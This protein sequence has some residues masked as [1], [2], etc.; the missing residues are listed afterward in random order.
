MASLGKL[1]RRVFRERLAAK[2]RMRFSV[3]VAYVGP[4]IAVTDE[5]WN[6]LQTYLQGRYGP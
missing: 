6:Q 3:D 5:Q 1:K 2:R 4:V